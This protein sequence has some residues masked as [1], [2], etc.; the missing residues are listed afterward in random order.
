MIKPTQYYVPRMYQPRCMD[1]KKKNLII[2]DEGGYVLEI[3][4]KSI[5]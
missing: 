2:G 1:N 5:V 3:N 4:E